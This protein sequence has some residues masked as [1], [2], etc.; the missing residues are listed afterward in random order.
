[1][2]VEISIKLKKRYLQQM[3]IMNDVTSILTPYVVRRV[4]HKII[5]PLPYGVGQSQGNQVETI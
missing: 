4:R 2:L 5:E 1:M 3:Q